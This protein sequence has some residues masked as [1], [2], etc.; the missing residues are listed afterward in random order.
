M[1]LQIALSSLHE[2]LSASDADAV[3]EK[4]GTVVELNEH[5]NLLLIYLESCMQAIAPNL[6]QLLGCFTASKLISLAGGVKELAA[7]PSCNIQVMGG[8]RSS[9]IGL[10]VG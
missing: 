1:S 10:N 5:N 9:Q 2:V 8:Q 4:A 3:L 7:I 6:C